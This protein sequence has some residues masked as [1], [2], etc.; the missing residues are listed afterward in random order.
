VPA[1]MPTLQPHHLD[2]LC[3]VSPD[4]CHVP[5]PAHLPLPHLPCLLTACPAPLPP[6]ERAAD[7][8]AELDELRA[9]R[10]QE[11]KEREWRAK[12]RS[13]AERAAA[14]QVCMCGGATRRQGPLA[15]SLPHHYAYVIPRSRQKGGV[16]M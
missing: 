3:C 9:R 2:S 11:A 8:Q 7:K 5:V 13:A 15:G 10:Y 14:M 1:Y 16:G 4:A 6:Q 12:E